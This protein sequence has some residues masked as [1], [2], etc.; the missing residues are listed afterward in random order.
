MKKIIIFILL[1][2]VTEYGFAQDTTPLVNISGVGYIEWKKDIQKSD[3]SECENTFAI[4]RVY[5]NFARKFDEVWSMRVTTDIGQVDSESTKKYTEEDGNTD[6]KV[7]SKTN[8][9]TVFLKFAYIQASQKFD[10]FGYS[11]Q[12][13]MVG[14]PLLNYMD[15]Q[16]DFRWIQKNYFDDAKNVIKTTIDY[17]ADLGVKGEM[18]FFKIITLT[19]A[20]TNG[21]GFQKVSE[22]DDG[23]AYYGMLTLTP[24]EHIGLIAFN[25]YCITN[26]NHRSDNYVNYSAFGASYSQNA[27]KI[28]AVY[29]LPKEEIN[30]EKTNYRIIDAYMH[31]DFSS[32]S[33]IPVILVGRFGYG[34]NIDD[35]ITTK[36]YS[37]GIGYRFNE[38]IRAVVYYQRKKDDTISKAD[39]TCY[40]KCSVSF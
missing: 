16:S 35:D 31:I 25:R 5:L 30:G 24:V 40:I 28:G 14:T 13:G 27:V 2:I 19:G 7:K 18:S 15:T 9:Y 11:L 6:S 38:A 21:E 26:D 12:F 39:K 20:I 34:K 10:S 29:A 22:T 23:K 3:N 32:T 1:A 36:I 17:S 33:I 8:N 4:N 37:G